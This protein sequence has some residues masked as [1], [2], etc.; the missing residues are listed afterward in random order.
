MAGD[1]SRRVTLMFL[2]VEAGSWDFGL[3]CGVPI[4]PEMYYEDAGPEYIFPWYECS[5][6]GE[7]QRKNL[8]KCSHCGAGGAH[9]VLR[10]DDDSRDE[11]SAL[12]RRKHAA[13]V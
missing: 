6:C 4:C 7:Y 2:N 12:W 11:L 13:Q 8:G 1:S 9:L 5:Q 3:R 10:Q